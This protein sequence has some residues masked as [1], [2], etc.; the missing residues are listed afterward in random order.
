MA[1]LADYPKIKPILSLAGRTKKPVLP[2]INYR[3]GGFGGVAGLVSYIK[4][5]NINAIVCATHPFA[6]KMPFNA[7]EAAK[8][9]DIPIIFLLRPAWKP[10]IGDNWME[11]ANH[12]EA[13]QQL[14]TNNQQPETIFLT[15]GRLDLHEYTSDQQHFYLVRSI[16]ELTEK[17]LKNAVYTA[18]RPPFLVE[19]EIALMKKY[20]INLLISKN[21]GGKATEAKLTAAREL[22]TPVIMI[23][24]P[25][26]PEGLHME[27]TKE[28]LDW[29]NKL[30]D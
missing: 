24:R 12:K 30:S 8:L 5:Q 7:H 15:V 23:K 19:D 18:V 26:R 9:A 21:S 22:K 14:T 17:P 27:T 13:I 2:Q 28:V 16:D 20:N 10:Q 3:I 11:V 25:P 29:L 6:S 4:S 1:L